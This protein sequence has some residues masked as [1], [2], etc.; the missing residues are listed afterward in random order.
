[1]S[2]KGNTGYFGQRRKLGIQLRKTGL[3]VLCWMVVALLVTIYDHL[4]ISSELSSGFAADYTF[5]RSLVFNLM[6]AVLGGTLGGAWLVFY[7]NER[8]RDK[9]YYFALLMVALS[10]VLIVAFLFFAVCGWVFY[11]LLVVIVLSRVVKN[12][13]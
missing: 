1:M 2:E 9:P 12:S 7:V 11:A 13:V 5:L 8:A 3:I 10:F 4:C 6:A